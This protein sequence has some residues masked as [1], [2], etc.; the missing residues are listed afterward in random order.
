MAKA[1]RPGEVKTRLASAIGEAGAADLYRD[2]LLDMLDRLV[3]VPGG[4]PVVAFA[5]ADAEPVFAALAP[6]TA[7]LPQRG[8]DLGA[9]LAHLF[10]DLFRS[11]Y[12]GAV[13]LGSDLPTLPAELLVG[14]VTRVA[15]A[16]AS[17]RPEVVLGPTE[18][19]GYY[20]IGLT[21]P[22]PMLFD[23]IAWSTARVLAQTEARAAAAGLPVVRLDSWFDVDVPAD[24]ER[25][26]R[27]LAGPEGDLAPRTRLRLVGR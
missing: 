8:D 19:G 14:A 12:Q 21:Q 9:R 5:P 10:D 11:G 23:G 2:F 1:P 26:R 20:L 16:A 17:G 24:L 22:A 15:G 25:L 18:D 3:R 4:T 27:S 7:R 13:V 6:D